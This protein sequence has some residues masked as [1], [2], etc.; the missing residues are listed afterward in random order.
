VTEFLAFLAESGEVHHSG[1]QFFWMADH[2][3]AQA[4]SLRS[5]SP[6]R[7]RLE[8]GLGEQT[9]TTIGEVDVASAP[10][11][12]HPQAV[13]L[14]EGASFVVESLDLEAN[15][16]LLRPSAGDH[17]TEPQRETTVELVERLAQAEA[18]GATK[19]HGEILVTEQVTGYKVV[20]F[21]TREKL[22]EGV[23][24]LPPS[25]L[26]T[27][28]YWLALTE[29]T[30]AQLREQNL[31]RNDPNDY[32][33][34][35]PAQ[36]NRVRARDGYRCQIC[37]APEQ[38]RQHDVHHKLP[39]RRFA[40]AR[41]ANQLSNLVTLCRACHRRAESA[42]KMRSGLGGLATVLGHLAPLF[43]MCDSHDLAVHA[44]PQS[45]LAEGR[46]AVL[47]YELIPAG[48]GFSERLF[49]LH[50]DLLH[51]A[52]TLV[53]RCPCPDGCPSCAGPAGEAGQGGKRETLAILGRLVG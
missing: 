32:G 13:Y 1:E 50:T 43:L 34:D 19:A 47:I 7:V 26:S 41:E 33:P 31:W 16:A 45:P 9:G 8:L 46:P 30:V 4:V 37:G 51:Q 35:W 23:V 6:A 18:P 49:E 22:G 11:M 52:H 3:P 40:T 42:V 53:T 48:L 10:W 29:A 38:G 2:Y 15:V 24:S 21:F 25:E 39:F 20:Q 36:R 5:A 28:G 17:Y 27:S 44:D 14:H 12:V